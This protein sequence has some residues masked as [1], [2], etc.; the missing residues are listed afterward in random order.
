ME[1][2]KGAVAQLGARPPQADSGGG[3]QG[4][5]P[6]KPLEELVQMEL[7]GLESFLKDQPHDASKRQFALAGKGAGRGAMPRQK[8]GIGEQGAQSLDDEMGRKVGLHPHPE[9]KSQSLCTHK[10]IVMRLTKWQWGTAPV[11]VRANA[12]AP[13]NVRT[14]FARRSPASRPIVTLPTRFCHLSSGAGAGNHRAKIRRMAKRWQNY[15]CGLDSPKPHRV[16]KSGL[17]P[18]TEADTWTRSRP[19]VSAGRERKQVQGLEI[20]L[21]AGTL[22]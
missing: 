7:D 3:R 5:R 15:R 1:F 14:A 19:R 20:Q 21:R 13:L 11:R 10:T 17:H 9:T 18:I 22:N 16:W 2:D 4:D 8:A 12:H 6:A